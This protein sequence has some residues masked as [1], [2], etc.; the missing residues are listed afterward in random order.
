[1]KLNR[2]SNE[3]V[4]SQDDAERRRHAR[5]GSPLGDESAVEEALRVQRQFD[6]ADSLRASSSGESSS[7]NEQVNVE[8]LQPGAIDIPSGTRRSAIQDMPGTNAA[9]KASIAA[10]EVV[11]LGRRVVW[12]WICSAAIGTALFA[13]LI[14]IYLGN[15]DSSII[16]L[17]AAGI[18]G[19]VSAIALTGSVY[20]KLAT[21]RID[22]YL[23]SSVDPVA[24]DAVMT[25]ALQT[26]DTLD[27][28]VISEAAI[29]PGEAAPGAPQWLLPVRIRRESLQRIVRH[30]GIERWWDLGLIDGPAVLAGDKVLYEFRGRRVRKTP[31]V[32]KSSPNAFNNPINGE[33]IAGEPSE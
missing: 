10:D 6:F 8:F 31:F 11:K 17:V 21:T 26:G 19:L 14:G 3:L 7:D 9:R 13:T 18:F 16:F 5:S 23:Q 1:L 25:D 33:D 29:P 12:T 2:D 20:L 15:A 22:R 27:E 4:E 28:W 30:A 32:R 24:L